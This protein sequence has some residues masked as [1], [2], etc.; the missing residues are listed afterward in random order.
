MCST[1]DDDLGKDA[2]KNE[3]KL[4]QNEIKGIKQDKINLLNKYIKNKL[5]LPAMWNP[6]LSPP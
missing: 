1:G 2:S 4:K 3:I 5:Q 6:I